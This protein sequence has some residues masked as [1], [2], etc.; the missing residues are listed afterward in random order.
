MTIEIEVSFFSLPIINFIFSL[1]QLKLFEDAKICMLPE[2]FLSKT[3]EKLINNKQYSDFVFICSDGGKIHVQKA[4]IA[5]HCEAFATM[6]AAGMTETE[7]NS[8]TITDIDSETMLELVRFLYCGQVK[9][10]KEVE[11]RLVIAANKYGLTLL[12][13]L[14]VSSM[15][16]TLD[17]D[18]VMEVFKIAD[19]V[20]E[21]NLKEYCVDHIK[22]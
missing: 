18:D 15:M 19:L 1:F 22:A 2:N 17:N 20:G 13:K 21:E 8:A 9:N 4:Y 16:E 3:N 7:T 6:I 10:M 5:V 14:C 12:Q 11:D